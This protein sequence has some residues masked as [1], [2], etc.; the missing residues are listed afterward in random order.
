MMK[1]SLPNA[2]AI[3]LHQITVQMTFLS[4]LILTKATPTRPSPKSKIRLIEKTIGTA[5]QIYHFSNLV[6]I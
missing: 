6:E 3:L 1:V 2:A 5:N 4:L